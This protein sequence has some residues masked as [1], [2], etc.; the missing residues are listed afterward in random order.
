MI[1]PE[2][3]LAQSIIQ[4]LLLYNITTVVIS[5]GSRNAP[6]T[7]G[8][9]SHPQFS[10][11]SVADERSAAFFAMGMAL[12]LQKPVAVI[13]TSGSAVLNFYPAVAEAFYSRIPLVVISADRPPHKIDIGD[14]QTIRQK[15]VLK[16][17]VSKSLDLP[18][19]PTKKSDRKLGKALHK[20]ISEQLPIHI[21]APFEEPLYRTLSDFDYRISSTRI[22]PSAEK[23]PQLDAFFN[24][25]NAAE[26]KLV[27]IGSGLPEQFTTAF[28]R[29][30]A[31]DPSVLVFTEAN[32]NVRHSEFINQIDSFISESNTLFTE[33]LRPDVLLSLGG[34]VVSKRI[35]TLLRSYTDLP[36]F[37]V[38][39]HLAY[40]T[41]G[42]DVQHLKMSL[43][44]FQQQFVVRTQHVTS[45]YKQKQL[46]RYR[47]K[48]EKQS[49]F[50][51]VAAFSDF[52]VF[53]L[54]CEAVPA[55]I[56]LHVSNSASIR[57][58]QLFALP[59]KLAV[60][61]NRGTSGIDGS[62]STAVGFSVASAK[63]TILITGDISFFY[64]SNGLWNQYIPQNFKIILINNGGGGIFRILPGHQEN[65]TFHTFFETAH[66]YTAEHLAKM[67]NFTYQTAA[68]SAQ[69]SEALK[70]FFAAS[71]RRI[72]EIFT[73]TRTNDLI[74]DQ[75]FTA[76][77]IDQL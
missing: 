38:D 35:K 75:Y 72:L 19:F 28:I 27:L 52:S 14:G 6:L 77:K 29:A 60:Y 25:W 63:A 10:C 16:N 40:N 70:A 65:E 4:H 48:L 51:A 36:H 17:H 1:V 32:S 57:Y 13:C 46:Q 18:E 54:I 56:A 42:L 9:A 34:M 37:H 49:E 21:N 66:C 53:K 39:A 44:S 8:F 23:Q 26:R 22:A 31:S 76:L 69:L 7:I 33:S 5:P 59:E 71:D 67:Y 61:C 41:F 15:H 45:T 64:D 30:L 74:L 47:R 20:A 11:Y 24:L 3:T 58:M 73:P 68:S 62:T 55:D 12:E 43:A 50:E 2:N